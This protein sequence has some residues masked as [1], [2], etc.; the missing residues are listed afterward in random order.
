[1][2]KEINMQREEN[3]IKVI[4]MDNRFL[5]NRRYLN[6]SRDLHLPMQLR[7]LRNSQVLMR[8]LQTL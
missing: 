5:M 6:H 2:A 7:K 3:S 8:D 1:M 4:Q